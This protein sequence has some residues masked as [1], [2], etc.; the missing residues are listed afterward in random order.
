MR[1]NAFNFLRYAKEKF[2]TKC[3]FSHDLA[4]AIQLQAHTLMSPNA[5]KGGAPVS[6]A[7]QAVNAL[8][9][10]P[11]TQAECN[12]P[13]CSF[14]AYVVSKVTNTAKKVDHAVIYSSVGLDV[15]VA[16]RRVGRS[17]YWMKIVLKTI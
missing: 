3:D 16:I 12:D 8:L 7:V 11:M 15:E 4:F 6:K 9:V 1:A 13:A 2:G 17:K 10:G 14:R 5:L